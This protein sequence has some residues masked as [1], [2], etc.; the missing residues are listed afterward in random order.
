MTVAAVTFQRV[1]LT[2]SLL[3]FGAGLMWS[4]GAVM[5]RAT[6]SS[7]AYQYLMW[8]AVAVIAVVEVLARVR[9]RRSSVAAAFTSGWS[10]IGASAALLLASIAF[11]Y[12]LKNTT[13]AN[14]AFLASVS[15][16]V[17]VVIARFVLGERL[18]RVTIGALL[19]ATFGLGVMV[20]SDV[21]IGSM[22]G[23]VAALGSAVGFASYTVFIRADPERDWS[24]VLPGYSI[25][26]I[27]ICATVTFAGGRAL[28][29]PAGDIAFAMVHG[30]VFIVVGTLMFNVASRSM[31]AVAMTVLAQSETVFVPVWIYLV[32]GERPGSQALLGAVIILTA[33]VG[34]ALFDSR[35]GELR[36]HRDVPGGVL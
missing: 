26:M 33:V 11:I 21:G 22:S 8:R 15:P 25:L 16:L 23:N 24:P 35:G 14:T 34:K 32:F 6:G 1:P 18:T 3:A 27:A 17:A 19:L 5:V 36:P 9:G 10:V 2:A 13:A 20:V 29:P 12:A 31:P 4:V 7:D 28:V 30:G